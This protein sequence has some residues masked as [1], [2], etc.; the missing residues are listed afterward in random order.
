M[1]NGDGN[2][3][4][5]QGE[6]KREKK[7]GMLGGFRESKKNFLEIKKKREMDKTTFLNKK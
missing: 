2:N 3:W 1:R 6:R 5:E 4:M 7:K